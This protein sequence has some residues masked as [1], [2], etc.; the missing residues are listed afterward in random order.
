MTLELEHK[1][2]PLRKELGGI[3]RMSGPIVIATS[4]RMFMDVTDFWMISRTGN[5]DALAAILPAQMIMYT[6][7]AL[8]MGTLGIVATFAAQSLGRGES[9]RCSKYAWQ[10][11]YLSAIAWL[12]GAALWPFLPDI[13]SWIGHD[14]A[15]RDLEI[16]YASIAVW[17]IGPTIAATGLSSYFN[18]IH[19]PVTTM[20]VALEGV[21]VNAAVSFILIF[22]M[23]GIQ[24]MGIEGAAWG[25]VAGTGYRVVRFIIVLWSRNHHDQFGSRSTW[26]MDLPRMT[27]ILRVGGPS[28]VQWGSD[29]LVWAIFT[30]VLVG[31]YFGKD[32]QLA[33]NAAWQYL[34]ISFMP[35]IGVGFA[36]SSL[37]GH[38][39]GMRDFQRAIRITRLVML[40]LLG[41]MLV[42]SVIFFA[43]RYQLIGFFD[44]DPDVIRI[45]ASVMICAALFQIFDA[46]GI[47]YSGAL[48]AAGDTLV[49]SIVY[50]L[51]HWILVVG[52]GVIMAE[53]FPQL[54]SLGPWI[55]ATVLISFTG[56]YYWWRW[57]GRAWTRIDIFSSENSHQT[58]QSPENAESIDP[59]AAT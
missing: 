19:R 22:G 50:M 23:F 33:T 15:I 53:Y 24:P 49:P 2:Q 58:A 43:F 40:M 38:A 16:R 7:M 34:R 48:R 31:R 42:M 30:T 39:I 41:Y 47:S 26:R 1:K 20:V 21:V 55:A 51:S 32:D 12:L 14:V 28:G 59:E 25:T 46:L 18:G 11:L 13:F 9:K 27:S 29:V 4:S 37:V 10:C 56:V 36:L 5:S 3:V 17:T 8:W 54:R 52:G 45:G 57:H 44:S 6:Y 35:A